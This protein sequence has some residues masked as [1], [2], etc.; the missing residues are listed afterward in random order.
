MTGKELKEFAALVHDNAVIQ[1]DW[2][3]GYRTDW[4]DLKQE[5]I[6]A[7][8]KASTSLNLETVNG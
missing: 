4:K 7:T 3:D 1:V 2:G 6:Q 8:L 5:D